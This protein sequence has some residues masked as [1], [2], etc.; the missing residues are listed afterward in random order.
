MKKHGDLLLANGLLLLSYLFLVQISDLLSTAGHQQALVHPE[1]GLALAF[2]Y[3][4]G[5]IMLPGITIGALITNLLSSLQSPGGYSATVGSGGT[6]ALAA[7]LQAYVGSAWLR[8]GWPELLW[9]RKIEEYQLFYLVVVPCACL[10]VPLTGAVVQQFHGVPGEQNGGMEILISWIGNVVGVYLVAPILMLM[11]TEEPGLTRKRRAR[12]LLPTFA[13]VL[14]AGLGFLVNREMAKSDVTQRIRNRTMM[15]ASRLKLRLERHKEFLRG[16]QLLFSHGTVMT[17]EEFREV[18]EL[19]LS[20]HD[21]IKGIS[22]NP[23]VLDEQRENFISAVRRQEGMQG[24]MI[25]ELA[26]DGSVVPARIHS[27]YVPVQYI[28][29]REENHLAIGFDIQSSPVRADA[30]RRAISTNSI[31]ATSAI[32]LV[33]SKKGHKTYGFLMLQP[34]GLKHATETDSGSRMKGFLVGVYELDVLLDSLF[35]EQEWDSYQFRLL[36]QG[37]EKLAEPRILASYPKQ[38]STQQTVSG[39]GKH[40][41]NYR[42]HQVPIEVAGQQWRLQVRDSTG[43]LGSL[44]LVMSG[45]IFQIGLLS[46][47]ILEGF[48]IWLTGSEQTSQRELERKLRTSLTTAAMAHEIKQPLSA[49][50]LHSRELERMDQDDWRRSNGQLHDVAEEISRNALRIN[51]V[52]DNIRDILNN[53][54]T[55]PVDIPV[56]D[57]VDHAVLLAKSEALLKDV[58]IELNRSVKSAIVFADRTQLVMAL[59]NVLRNSIEAVD[60][61]GKIRIFTRLRRNWVDILICDNG[62]GFSKEVM[63]QNYYGLVSTK[64]GGS[65]LG[66]FLCVSAV[67]NNKGLIRLGKSRMGGAEVRISLPREHNTA[68]NEPLI[69]E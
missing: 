35:H 31:Q 54:V 11:L 15:A 32:K 69:K 12:I 68:T 51:R 67:E 17:P 46:A 16:S 34:V 2:A 28:E 56:N 13:L 41:E 6:L 24:Y 3:G 26:A 66:L 44:P 58:D 9:F 49:L 29:P 10:I 14:I 37:E 27:S 48:L 4:R 64:A 38:I 7:T 63:D 53:A 33:Q 8:K 30:I 62:P 40:V 60:Q 5:I 43:Q 39:T 55:H 23:F 22:W 19:A 47:C 45:F 52:I 21:G 61:G 57:L 59:K 20:T 65:G 1:A 25:K 42:Q 18:A 50:L 36:D